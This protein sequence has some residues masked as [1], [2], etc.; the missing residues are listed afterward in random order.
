MSEQ[1]PGYDAWKTR[2]PGPYWPGKET[3]MEFTIYDAPADRLQAI[4]ALAESAL[5]DAGAEDVRSR[6][7]RTDITLTVRIEVHASGRTR[8]AWEDADAEA[9]GDLERAIERAVKT[10]GVP[11][12][13]VEHTG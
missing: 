7:T 6:V 12:G 2:E 13:N 1:L 4:E 9:A 10:E 5:F 11:A 8:E 3:E